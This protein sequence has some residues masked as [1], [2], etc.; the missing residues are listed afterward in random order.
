MMPPRAE[1]GTM[2]SDT[3]AGELIGLSRL[4]HEDI[5]SD[6]VRF[7]HS[8]GDPARFGAVRIDREYALGPKAGFADLHVEPEGEPP[9]FLEVKYGY[10]GETLLRHLLRKYAT[11]SPA[12]AG[13]TKVVLAVETAARPDW[14]ALEAAI[15]AGLPRGPPLPIAHCP[16]ATGQRRRPRRPWRPRNEHAGTAC[17]PA[18]CCPAALPTRSAPPA[19]PAN[20]GASHPAP[21]AAPGA[22][23]A[24]VPARDGLPQPPAAGAGP[25]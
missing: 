25:R 22:H 12:T 6:L 24:S 1:T 17:A 9:Y 20:R 13:A 14:P 15:R 5:C 16:T 3:D 2:E 8:G 10:D 7:L 18:A 21:A 4:L 23:R 11:P 19:R